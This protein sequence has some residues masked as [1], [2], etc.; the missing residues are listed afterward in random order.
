LV[1][2]AINGDLPTNFVSIVLGQV[3]FGSKSFFAMQ[4]DEGPLARVRPLVNIKIALAVILLH[5]V[6]V[7]TLVLI[8]WLLHLLVFFNSAWTVKGLPTHSGRARQKILFLSIVLFRMRLQVWLVLKRLATAKIT[9]R[10]TAQVQLK[11]EFSTN[12]I[13]L[14]G[15]WKQIDLKQNLHGFSKALSG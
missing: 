10:E 13:K 6:L 11:L 15:V 1:N 4:T 2:K 14:S 9:A 8:L 7:G 3:A 5:A 12:W